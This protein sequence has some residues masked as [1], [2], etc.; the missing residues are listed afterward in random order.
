MKIVTDD[1]VVDMEFGTG[2]VKISPAHDPEDF[3]VGER[4]NLEFINILNDDGTLNSNA[5]EEFQVRGLFQLRFP[6]FTNG[7][8][9]HR[10]L[11]NE[12]IPCQG[13][14]YPTTKGAGPLLRSEGSRNAASGVL[15][16]VDL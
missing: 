15:V 5:G 8:L 3:R 16:G 11:G 1:E 6:F 12:T 13:E 4:H 9:R 7:Q 10:M 14:G 2:V